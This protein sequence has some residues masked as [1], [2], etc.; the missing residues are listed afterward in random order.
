MKSIF[1]IAIIVLSLL[2]NTAV[3]G[4]KTAKTVRSASPTATAVFAAVRAQTLGRGVLV[5]WQTSSETQN[6]GFLVYRVTEKG[7]ELVSKSIIPG[8][9][10]RSRVADSD[11]GSYSLFDKAGDA[12]TQYEIESLNASGAKQVS[13]SFAAE[14]VSSFSPEAA[15]I[16]Q[17]A[18]APGGSS[19]LTVENTELPSSTVPLLSNLPAHR[20]IM[21]MSGARIG[22]KK[23]GFYRISRAELQSAGFNLSGSVNNWQLYLNGIEQPINVDPSGNYL[24][25]YGRGIDTNEADTRIY[26]LVAGSSAGKRISSAVARPL[27]AQVAANSYSQTLIHKER[28]TY[29]SGVLNGDADNY[30]GPVISSTTTNDVLTL[31]GVDLNSTANVVIDLTFQGLTDTPHQIDLQI[32]NNTL[33]SITGNNRQSMS[34]H[35]VVPA[36]YLVEGANTLKITETTGFSL[37]DTFKFTYN[38]KFSAVQNQLTAQTQNY[39]IAKFENFSSAN[40]RVFDISNPTSIVQQSNLNAVQNGA[41][42]SVTLPSNRAKTLL[43][44]ENSGLLTAASVTA[45]TPSTLATTNHNAAFVVISHGNFLTQA[46]NWAA[47][48]LSQGI[49]TEVVNVEDIY[50][51][52]NFGVL[53][54]DSIRS[55]LQYA[56]TNWQTPPQYVLLIGDAT[57]DPRNYSGLGN[58]NFVPT[59]LIDTVYLETGSDE[60]LADFDDDGLSEIAIG[61]IPARTAQVV[62]DV[63]AKVQAYE[64]GIA[65]TQSRGAVFVSDIPNGYDFAG[66]NMRLGQQLPANMPKTFINRGDANSSANVMTALNAGPFLVNYSGHGNLSVWATSGFFSSVNVP[67]LTNS[68]TNLSI[69]TMLTCLNGYFIEISPNGGDSLSEVLL[70][71]NTGGA[72]AV[73]ASTGTTT[74]DIQEIMGTRFYNQVEAGT[75]TRLGDLIKDAKTVIPGGRDVRLSWCLLGDPMTKMK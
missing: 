23:T 42:Y 18:A 44:V 38:R 39:K 21:A 28:T 16:N 61:R 67:S 2:V 17:A 24:E 19:D 70:K 72:A 66:V 35:Y 43:A 22:V 57:Y 11:G 52:F 1:S 13:D 49:S 32:N 40:V 3:F 58:N 33:N 10:L 14:S 64:T 15:E 54:A 12:N 20:A 8:N 63:L 62:T 36:S 47:Y 48:R 71:S 46:N 4:Q 55:F 69:Y 74:P 37:I 29:A 60:A 6:L 68:G 41:T 65:N 9:Y 5:K 53:S 34:G 31:T 50:D 26:Y 75:F 51:E 59:K 45:N 73:W 27:N 25:F 56:K 30:F 7:R